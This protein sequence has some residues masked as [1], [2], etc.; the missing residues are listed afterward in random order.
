MH[1]G[2]L[3]GKVSKEWFDGL[4]HNDW[5]KHKVDHPVVSPLQSEKGLSS[6]ITFQSE[7]ESIARESGRT[8]GELATAWVLR[9]QEVTSAIVGARKKGQISEICKVSEYPLSNDEETLV[10]EALSSY[11][12]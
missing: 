5:R 11:S 3:T 2:L 10:G 7:L 1:S 6:F 4:P 9:R 8:I 12:S